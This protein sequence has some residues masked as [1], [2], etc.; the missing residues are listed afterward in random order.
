MK[1]TSDAQLKS[2]VLLIAGLIGIGYQQ[3]TGETNWLLLGIFTLMAGVPGA[4]QLF[5]LIKN[6]PIVLQSSLSRREQSEL[7]SENAHIDSSEDK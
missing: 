2:W 7:D 6:S 5:S 4:T 1:E 3:Y